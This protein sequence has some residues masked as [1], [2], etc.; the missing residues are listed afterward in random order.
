MVLAHYG[1]FGPLEELRVECGVAR[2]GATAK[3]LYAAARGY[4]MKPRAFK[5]EPEDLKDL[6]LPLIVHWRFAHFFV[7]EGYYQGDWY[8]ND[9]AMGPRRCD[10]SEFDEAF[11]GGGAGVHPRR[12]FR[13]VRQ[14]IWRRWPAAAGRRQP[15]P[16][17]GYGAFLG[18]LLLVPTLVASQ[19]VR[20]FGSQLA[21]RQA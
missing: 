15:A 19:L 11:T 18:L 14:A 20:L 17:F 12:R 6:A 4:G 3:N 1:K 2:D 5:R 10:D 13:P 16:I 7:V 8:L 21:G 9:P